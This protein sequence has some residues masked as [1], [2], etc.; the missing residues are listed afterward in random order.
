MSDKISKDQNNENGLVHVPGHA[1]ITTAEEFRNGKPGIVLVPKEPAGP[2]ADDPNVDFDIDDFESSNLQSKVKNWGPKIGGALA[3]LVLGSMLLSRCRSGSENVDAGPTPTALPVPTPTS[4]NPFDNIDPNDTTNPLS[5]HYKDP[6]ANT[7]DLNRDARNDFSV[8]PEYQKLPILTV[9]VT[10]RNK[11]GNILETEYSGYSPVNAENFKRMKTVLS[12][13]VEAKGKTYTVAQILTPL[14]D[15]RGND[16]PYKVI[17]LNVNGDETTRHTIVE[18]PNTKIRYSNGLTARETVS[19]I[20]DAMSGRAPGYE[21]ELSF[22]D[23]EQAALK[24]SLNQ[25]MKYGRPV[26][27]VKSKAPNYKEEIRAFLPQ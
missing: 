2:S 5:G 3:I 9:S 11:D 12:H 18:D 27:P 22:D 4:A 25:A 26:E 24:Y 17:P 20:L 13:A 1:K 7:I 6:S 10:H 16:L 8:P 19:F 14:T 15:A 23:A 21:S